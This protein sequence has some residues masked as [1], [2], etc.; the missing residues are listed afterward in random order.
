MH[1]CF[2]CHEFPNGEVAHGGFG[3]FVKTI[4]NS[5]LNAGVEVSVIF[6]HNT[7]HTKT[8]DLN[9]LS[10]YQKKMFKLPYISWLFNSILINKVIKKI[11][12]KSPISIIETSE[13]DLAFISKLKNI[14]Y[15]IRL[16]GGHHFF[17]KAENRKLNFWKAY[18]EKKSFSKADGFIAVSEHVR[19]E[20]Q[21]YL[22]FNKKKIQVISNPIDTDFFQ[23]MSVES[24]PFQIVFAGTVCEKK[25]IRQL[26]RAFA[27]VKKQFPLATLQIYGRDWFF[28]NGQSYTKMLQNDE[29][30]P[31]GDY[32]KDVH[33]HGAVSLQEIKQKY[34]QAHVCVFPSHSEAQGL[35]APEAMAMEKCVVFTEIGPGKETIISFENGLLCNP[36][37][38]QDI[39]DKICW[40]FCNPDKVKA[41]EISAR[42]TVLEKYELHLITQKNINF[43]DAL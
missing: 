11:H 32:S 5:L 38:I 30:L 37:D 15:V 6:L 14:N 13:L 29:I 17:S 9:G 27:L 28:P 12:K 26:I 10:L 22:S 42:K 18:Q 16:H 36:F 23:P 21:N 39:A 34:A 43:Y 20:T 1:I 7:I 33:F 2:I 25:G 4:S 40:V 31:L 19:N 8:I 41:I 35:V 24:I 3:T